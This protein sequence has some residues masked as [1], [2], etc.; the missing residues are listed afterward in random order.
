MDDVFLHRIGPRRS[1]LD[2]TGAIGSMWYV[3]YLDEAMAA[4]L[5][6]RGVSL[7]ELAAGG[8]AIR[9]AHAEL[10][11]HAEATSAAPLEIAVSTAAVRR[12]SFSLDFEVR[13]SGVALARGH[14]VYVVTRGDGAGA[15][16]DALRTALEPVRPLRADRLSGWR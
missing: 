12:T 1:E 16:P 14:T 10:D 3:A 4:F 13:R 2:S 15:L 8:V 7:D 6:G 11:W 5:T 9:A